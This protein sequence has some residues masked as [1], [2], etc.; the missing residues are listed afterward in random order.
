MG[1][2][3]DQSFCGQAGCLWARTASLAVPKA[4]FCSDH[5]PALLVPLPT[6]QVLPIKLVGAM[7]ALL[8]FWLC[9]RLSFLLPAS[10]RNDVVARLGNW[11]CRACLWWLGFWR[12]TWIKVGEQQQQR[13]GRGGKAGGKAGG[14]GGGKAARSSGPAEGAAAVGIVSNHIS[15]C[16]ILLHMSRSFP[17]FVA[18]SQT[19]RMP[20]V[21]II[22]W[23]GGG[24][25]AREATC[26]CSCAS[27][28]LPDVH[29]LAARWQ[30][31]SR[32][33]CT[34][35]GP[36]PRQTCGRCA[37]SWCAGPGAPP[38]AAAAALHRFLPERVDLPT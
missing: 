26:A 21:G 34:P 6:C 24:P 15:W 28:W 31:S 37:V 25:E 35:T 29:S 12:V 9:C 17:A 14:R 16:D 22:R 13:Q 3:A 5:P 19:R 1:A 7:T 33:W 23:A 10:V 2:S 36:S 30:A 38:A 4:C 20:I 27:L 32:R 11:H 18:R 8:S